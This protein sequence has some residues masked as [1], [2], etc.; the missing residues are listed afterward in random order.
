MIYFLLSILNSVLY[1]NFS[2]L[3]KILN[4]YDKPDGKLKIHNIK[5]PLLG[6]VIFFLNFILISFFQLAFSDD[7]LML[8]KT[9]F[10]KEEIISI[11]FFVTIF[12]MIGLY[13]D[14]NNISPYTKLFIVIISSIILLFLNKNLIVQNFLL[15]FYD[16][17]IFLNK[18]SIFF[19]IFCIVILTN[20]LNFYDGINGQSGNIY[21]IVFSYL[22]FKS[23]F[24][25]FYLI[26]I[27]P[28]IFV[29][30]LNLY[31]KL[32]FGDCGVY[33]I[34]S[35]MIICLIYEHNISKNIIYADEIFFLFLLPGLDLVRLTIARL[36][37]NKNIFYGDRN[38]FHHYLTK[39]FDLT[40]SNILLISFNLIP[41]IFL[42]L[43]VNF[44]YILFSY[45][46]V[47]FSFLY[48]LMNPKDEI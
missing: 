20:S 35:I 14:K 18:F 13:D 36:F 32:F 19:T 46:I 40:V 48:Y 29:L 47:Y 43:G 22:Y 16:N 37:L 33:L 23:D 7:F 25:Y 1:F 31:N 8:K 12:F 21:I 42:S 17:Q 38:H 3:S 28:L 5:T 26:I 9:F 39:K 2:K 45:L 4:I 30:V 24:N 27:L 10:I 15:S 11:I 44:Y 6:G 41:I 34:S